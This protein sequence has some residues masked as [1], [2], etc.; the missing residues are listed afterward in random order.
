MGFRG[1]IA[2]LC[3]VVIS[4]DVFAAPGDNAVGMNIHA[5]SPPIIAA[6]ADLGMTW[7]RVDAN[8]FQMEPADDQY[9]WRPMDAGVASASQAGLQVFMTLAYTPPWVPR[10]GDT[11]GIA[12]NDVPNGSAE[13]ASFVT[14]AV[15]RYRAMGV[16]HFGIWNEP[17]LDHFFEGTVAE[18]ATLIAIPGAAAVRAACADCTVLG[19]DLAH[20]GAVDDWLEDLLGRIPLTT[21]DI[22]SHHIYGGFPETGTQI[23]DGDRF[24]N[25]L[26]QQRFS[27]TRRSLRQILDGAG[28]QGEVWITE[29]GYRASP[30]GDQTAESNQATYVDRVIDEQLAR[31]WYTN[32]FFYEMLDCRPFLPTCDIDGFGI[33]RSTGTTDLNTATFPADFTRKP[34]YDA[35]K[36]RIAATPQ[37]SGGGAPAPQCGDGTDNDNDGRIDVA[38]RGCADAVDNDESDDPPRVKLTAHA[39]PGISVDGDLSDFGNAGWV[40][41]GDEG[42]RGTEPLTAGDLSVRVAARWT[43]TGLFVGLAVTDDVHDND[44]PDAE[45]WQAD[46]VQ[47]AFD[48]G[49]SGGDAYDI[50]DDH[51][52]NVAFARGQPRVFRHHGPNGAT[53]AVNAVVVR[54]GSVTRYELFIATSALPSAS[55]TA[56]RKLGFSFI[57]NDADSAGRIG[58]IEWT[59]GIGVTKAPYWFGEIELSALV[60]PPAVS[61][62]A[63]TTMEAGTTQDTGPAGSDARV[64]ADSGTS[65]DAAVADATSTPP[66]DAGVAV[67]ATSVSPT[68]DVSDDCSCASSRTSGAPGWLV[69][70]LVAALVRLRRRR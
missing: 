17:N 33:I 68:P 57:V 9:A 1:A 34:A 16:T 29:T 42:W 10:H 37:L 44:R 25:S 32:T 13:W 15:T 3:V 49:Q 23:W 56:G 27:F 26:D 45:L 47:L 40:D 7:V 55:F 70:G 63:G 35:L 19:P 67:D 41:I 50:V 36:Q 5:A 30:V 65:R 61:T 22:I 54:S 8:W 62:D 6:A 14:A 24:F 12:T 11:D 53:D 69:F 38:D 64:A 60:D 58:W 4:G 21:F 20:V 31:A 66:M 48:V 43:A 46:S 18:Y 39:T 2:T 52:I 59:R 51:E 28:Y